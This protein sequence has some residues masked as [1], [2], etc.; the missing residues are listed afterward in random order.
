MISSGYDKCFEYRKIFLIF[1]VGFLDVIVLYYMHFHS[2]ALG[3]NLECN[4][5][6][7]AHFVF[8]ASLIILLLWL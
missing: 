2:K 1:L 3:I 7:G 4:L 5:K 8:S 6:K